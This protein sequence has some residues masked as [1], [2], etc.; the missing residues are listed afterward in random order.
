MAKSARKSETETLGIVG[1]FHRFEDLAS[2]RV[3]VQKN[4]QTN[5]QKPCIWGKT[6]KRRQ[7]DSKQTRTSLTNEIS[8]DRNKVKECKS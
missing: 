3:Y 1:L 4:K 8:I 5:K 2:K 6:G 7:I